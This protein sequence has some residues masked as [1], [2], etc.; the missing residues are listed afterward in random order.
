M[1]SMNEYN[2]MNETSYLLSSPNNAKH[3]RESIEQIKV[4]KIVEREFI[5]CD[6]SFLIE[7]GMITFIDKNMI[8]KF[9]KENKSTY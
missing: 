8:S 3:I 9:F 1:I 5:E 4:G 7:V 2:S 6:K